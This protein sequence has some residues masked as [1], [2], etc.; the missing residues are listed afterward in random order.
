MNGWPNVPSE[1]IDSDGTAPR[2]QS[3]NAI[4]VRMSHPNLYRNILALALLSVGLGLNFIFTTPTFN[5]YGIPKEVVGGIFLVIGSTKIIFL[6]VYRSL[7]ALR[8]VMAIATAFLVFWGVGTSITFF[9]GK[10]SLQLF[11]LYIFIAIFQIFLMVEPFFNPMTAQ[12]DK[13]GERV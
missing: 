9:Q 6:D 1:V 8:V 11:L 12:Q 3:Y 10:T 7:R 2:T 13:G 4:N 5:P